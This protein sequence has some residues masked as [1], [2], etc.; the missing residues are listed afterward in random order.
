MM[1]KE[2]L[3]S[4]EMPDF[5]ISEG[6]ASQRKAP[7]ISSR[8]TLSSGLPGRAKRRGECVGIAGGP[9]ASAACSEM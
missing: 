5:S 3:Q 2:G 9:E 1:W 6:K 4:G 7:S 8:S